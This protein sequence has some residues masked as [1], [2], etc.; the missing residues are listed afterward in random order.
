MRH[1]DLFSG[2]GG[3][4]LAVDEVFGKSEHIFCEID[5]YCRALL[6]KRFPDGIMFGDIRTLTKEELCKRCAQNVDR[7]KSFTVSSPNAVN[8]QTQYQKSGIRTTRT[9]LKNDIKSGEKKTENIVDKEPRNISKDTVEKCLTHTEESVSVA[10][11]QT[12]SFYLSTTKTTTDTKT[13]KNTGQGR[14]INSALSGGSPPPTKSCATTAI[15]QEQSMESVRTKEKTNDRPIQ[16]ERLTADTDKQTES[17]LQVYGEKGSG[18]SN[19]WEANAGRVDILTGGF[20][21]QPFSQAGKRKGTEDNR[22]LWPEML[23]VIRDFKPTWVL[24]ENVRGILTIEGGMVFEQVCLDLEGEGYEVQ[25]FV[26][27]AV[28]KNAPHRRDRVWFVA[29][30]SDR[31]CGG[32]LSE[33]PSGDDEQQVHLEEEKQT[34]DDLRSET[35]RCGGCDRQDAPDT[36]PIRNPESTGQPCSLDRQG[37]VQYG[38]TGSTGNQQWEQNWLSVASATCSRGVD[39]GLPAELHG[40]KLSKSRHR[41]ERL[42]ALGNAIVPQ[43]AME[44]MRGIKL[45]MEV[46]QQKEEDEMSMENELKRIADCLER[47]EAKMGEVPAAVTT[48]TGNAP[49]PKTPKPEKKEEKPKSRKKKEKVEEPVTPSPIDVKT[50]EQYKKR[51]EEIASLI[52]G[53]YGDTE[54]TNAMFAE[55]QAEFKKN[56]PNKKHVFDVTPKEQQEV[57]FLVEGLLKSKGV[58]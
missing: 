27:P 50:P 2:I 19:L 41:V 38:G 12:K 29:N 33:Q 55:I 6:T 47:I 42:K 3:F 25:A 23:R 13:E 31:G 15:W 30:R 18:V 48:V 5:D 49:E 1:I 4:A 8:V 35:C 14:C 37:E 36:E 45:T 17:A 10:G 20:P 22:Y 54:K 56:Y 40:L 9:G 43:V 44:I 26:I 51:M 58:I 32:G 28:A 34:R 16:T 24:A 57:L 11:K 7:S 21:C 39:D 46:T 52:S 53:F